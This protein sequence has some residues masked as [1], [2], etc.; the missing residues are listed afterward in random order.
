[1]YHNPVLLQE[2]IDG[3]AI[4]PDGIYVDVTFGGGGHA[5]EIIKKLDTGRLLGF[6]QDTD[7]ERNIIHDDRFIFIRANFRFMRNFLKLYKLYPVDGILADLGVSSHQ[8]DEP[9]RG[10][11]TRFNAELDMRMDTGSKLSGKKVLNTY[12][13]N[14]LKR[15][16]SEFG[17]IENAGRLASN[18][19]ANRREMPINTTGDLIKAI[20]GCYNKKLENKYLARV[21][22]AVRIEVNNEI[23]ILKEF[24][25]QTVEALKAEGRIAVI[26]YHSLEDRLVKNFF[27]SGNFE[28]NINK[29]FYGNPLVQFKPINRR[30]IIA[31]EQEIS[32]NSRA[33]SAKLRIAEKI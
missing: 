22:Q 7:A 25:N 26:S 31:G 14:E 4:K 18:I 28:G 2:C 16:F 33:R 8:F 27:K 13:E 1:M 19:V 3:L 20:G 23:G 21:F 10:F 12:S 32:E 11:S 30:P 15:I 5:R 6:D 17:E 24:L 9:A 29:D